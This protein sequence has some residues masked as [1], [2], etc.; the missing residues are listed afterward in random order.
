M[1]KLLLF[2]WKFSNTPI[3]FLKTNYI[4]KTESIEKPTTPEIYPNIINDNSMI[5]NNTSDELT[6]H[7]LT[8]LDDDINWISNNE[9]FLQI[10]N[11]YH[12][13]IIP[14]GIN[15]INIGCGPEN[16]IMIIGDRPGIDNLNFNDFNWMD[17]GHQQQSSFTGDE[18]ILLKKMLNYIQINP[19]ECY[20]TTLSYWTPKTDRSFNK[21]ETE[22]LRKF[23]IKHIGLI[24][25]KK[26]LLLGNTA[27]HGLLNTTKPLNNLRGTI[28]SIGSIPVVVS[29][30]PGFIK[31][32]PNFATE[33]KKDMDLFKNINI[34]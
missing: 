20:I 19:E 27:A 10:V 29:F 13:I 34:N 32:F 14:D 21:K 22:L 16:N 4:L 6:H 7:D 18:K 9:Q 33:A 11:K 24:K 12:K 5:D 31:R 15:Y 3:N 30:N 26:I 23:I 28:H 8:K 2:D 17:Y 1:K 25:P